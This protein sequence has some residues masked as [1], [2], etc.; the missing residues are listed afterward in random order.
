MICPSLSLLYHCVTQNFFNEIVNDQKAVTFAGYLIKLFAASH[1]SSCGIDII[2]QSSRCRT[3]QI[4]NS[5]TWYRKAYKDEKTREWLNEQIENASDVFLIVGYQTLFNAKVNVKKNANRQTQGTAEQPL[6]D[7][8]THGASTQL[9]SSKPLDT[10]IKGASSAKQAQQA[11]LIGVEE[12]LYAVQFRSAKFDFRKSDTF[13]ASKLAQ[14]HV[15]VR[16]KDARTGGDDEGVDIVESDLDDDFELE[17]GLSDTYAHSDAA[18]ESF[19]YMFDPT[20]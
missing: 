15:W 13:E 17:S 8:V 4:D 3:Y 20:D 9:T 18:G 10:S 2:M 16:Y 5:S 6:T 11:S 1:T 7:A 19:L 14:E 12:Q